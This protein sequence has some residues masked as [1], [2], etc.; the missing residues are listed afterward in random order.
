MVTTMRYLLVMTTIITIFLIMFLG[1]IILRLLE[2]NRILTEKSKYVD[3]ANMWHKLAVTDDLT[4]VYN[5]NAYNLYV[6]ENIKN[7]KN[8]LIGIILFDVDNFK[9][10]NDTQGHLA[11]DMVLKNVAKNIAE[12]FP[13][14]QH[15]V[16][17]IGGDEFSVI[18]KGISESEII[19]RLIDLTKNLE[20][21]GNITLSKGYSIIKDNPEEAF[22]YADE[23]L[24]A[25]KMAKKK[26]NVF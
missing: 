16:F 9:T 18:T 8:K 17:R 24:Y 14:P 21:D 13:K 5:R 22:K 7:I 12:I 26:Y 2:K 10:I 23:M 1:V 20:M 11:G 25:D 3:E 4:G 6:S 15:R 19:E